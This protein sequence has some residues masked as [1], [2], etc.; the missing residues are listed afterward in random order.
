MFVLFVH[1]LFFLFYKTKMLHELSC[2]I[3]YFAEKEEKRMSEQIGNLRSASET[4]L[5]LGISKPT[6]TRLVQAGKIG[7]YRIG[8]RLLFD[9]QKHITPF[10]ESCERKARAGREQIQHAN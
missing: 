3:F 9:E 2:S 7:F 5:R 1:S 10:L 8:T 6:L 4:V